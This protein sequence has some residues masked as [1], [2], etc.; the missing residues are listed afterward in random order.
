ML[1]GTGL[2]LVLIAICLI[3]AL[4]S[5]RLGLI[6][7]IP[8]ATPAII[9]FGIWGILVGEVGLSA[10]IVTAVTLGVIVDNTVHFLSKF[11]RARRE[12]AASAEDAVRYAFSTVGTALWVTSVILIAGCAILGLSSFQINQTLGILTAIIIFVALFTDFL[13]L[14]PLLILFASEK[15]R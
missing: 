9:A 5:F 2:A 8:N 12:Q 11:Q 15:T 13:L 10:S 1:G 14:P 7:L 4:R 3:I 6:S